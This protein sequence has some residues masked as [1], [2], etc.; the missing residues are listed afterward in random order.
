MQL[1]KPLQVSLFFLILNL[2]AFIPSRAQSFKK[3]VSQIWILR[4]EAVQCTNECCT[5]FT[6]P[7]DTLR[8]E[9]SKAYA[10]ELPNPLFQWHMKK[11]KKLIQSYFNTKCTMEPIE[12]KLRWK[13]NNRIKTIKVGPDK[14]HMK[15]YI[16]DYFDN[17]E[18]R[19]VAMEPL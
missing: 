6:V 16:I 5:T 17:I 7:D 2:F 1:T 13:L 18:L 15:E 9:N 3:E 12:K 11:G 10:G 8:F 14:K 4:P 19:L